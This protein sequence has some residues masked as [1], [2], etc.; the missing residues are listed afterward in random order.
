MA[1]E[2]FVIGSGHLTLIE[3]D[4]FCIIV[5]TTQ[6]DVSASYRAAH[7]QPSLATILL[8][9]QSQ[10]SLVHHLAKLRVLHILCNVWEFITIWLSGSR[11]K[12]ELALFSRVKNCRVDSSKLHPLP[13]MSSLHVVIIFVLLFVDVLLF[14]A[15]AH[16]MIAVVGD[17][18]CRAL[19]HVLVA[20]FVCN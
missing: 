15:S 6:S 18:C 3:Y 10:Y 11:D 13:H 1:C 20:T 14:I 7:I 19:M 4:S 16:V 5:C 2:Y 8:I 9:T 12:V 17:R